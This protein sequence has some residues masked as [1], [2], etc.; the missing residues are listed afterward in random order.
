MN[1]FYLPSNELIT[2]PPYRRGI[3]FVLHGVS[4]RALSLSLFLSFFPKFLFGITSIC[5]LLTLV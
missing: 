1:V 3:R 2:Y 4:D 5:V